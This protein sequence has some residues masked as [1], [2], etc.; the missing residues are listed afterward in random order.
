MGEG[1]FS[2]T[3]K[4][5]STLSSHPSYREALSSLCSHHG[6]F[7]GGSSAKAALPAQAEGQCGSMGEGAELRI[8]A[9][10]PLP[11]IS[12]TLHCFYH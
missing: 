7:R 1:T 10:P 12:F 2:A 3:T 5:S 11:R 4:H 6:S 8:G 9:H